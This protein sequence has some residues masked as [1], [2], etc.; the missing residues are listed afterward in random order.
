MGDII[1]DYNDNFYLQF[2]AKISILENDIIKIN[3]FKKIDKNE[4][5]FL[6]ILK[7]INKLNSLSHNDFINKKL[8]YTSEDYNIIDNYSKLDIRFYEYIQVF[9]QYNSNQNKEIINNNLLKIFTNILNYDKSPA[10]DDKI[11][12]ELKGYFSDII[13][14][15]EDNINMIS[16]FLSESDEITIRQ[17]KR[18]ESI[19]KE[20]NP[21]ERIIFQ[22]KNISSILTLFIMDPNLKYNHLIRYINDIKNI[23]AR[24]IHMNN[25][26]T[27]L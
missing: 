11:N 1:K 20:Y 12:I 15:I 9:N 17:K 13:Y 14:E 7:T 5:N 19:F 24:L 18:F 8:K 25:T 4:E 23:L 21:A 22:S 3:Q 16:K 10:I 2:Y 26:N 6:S 27:S